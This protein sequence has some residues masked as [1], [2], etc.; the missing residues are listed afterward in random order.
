MDENCYYDA[1]F[2]APDT[3][4][5]KDIEYVLLCKRTIKSQAEAIKKD[6]EE[7]GKNCIIT[8]EGGEFYVWWS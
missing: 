5:F 6:M 8:A 3:R 4:K 2:I 1:I 7:R